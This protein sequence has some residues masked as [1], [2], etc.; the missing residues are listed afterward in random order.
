MGF[1]FNRPS[2]KPDLEEVWGVGAGFEEAWDV[3]SI[4]PWRS[5]NLE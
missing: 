3:K 4:M 2:Q 5:E 1:D